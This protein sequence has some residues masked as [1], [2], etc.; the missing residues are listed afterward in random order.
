ML[1]FKIED[2]YASTIVKLAPFTRVS[3]HFYAYTTK[4]ASQLHAFDAITNFLHYPMMS[5]MTTSSNLMLSH[6]GK[7]SLRQNATT[8][9]SVSVSAPPFIAYLIA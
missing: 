2:L 4:Q 1:S 6:K 3:I 9:Q 7:M 5:W 8:A